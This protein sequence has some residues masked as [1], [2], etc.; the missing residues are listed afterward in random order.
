MLP[1]VCDLIKDPKLENCLIYFHDKEGERCQICRNS[2]Y[3]TSEF[4]CKK[5]EL[6]SDNINIELEYFFE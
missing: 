6:D 2:Y 3:M 4:T 1:F 5:M